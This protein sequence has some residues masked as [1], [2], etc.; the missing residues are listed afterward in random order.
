MK[1]LLDYIINNQLVIDKGSYLTIVIGQITVYA[2]LLTFYQFIVLFQGTKDRYVQRYLGTKLKDYFVKK[3]LTIYNQ[4]VS[5]PWFGLLFIL[6]ILYKPI[7]SIYGKV[8]PDNVITVFNFIWYVYIVF[9][10]VVFVA[11]FFQ[12]MKCILSIELATDKRCN[13][14]IIRCINNEFRK[15]TFDDRLKKSSIKML[16]EAM[17][18]ISNS[19]AEDDDSELQT[20]YNKLIIDIFDDY[21]KGKEK[22][23]SLLL[24]KNK[25]GKNHTE[26]IDNMN[27]ERLLLSEFISGKYTQMN[28]LLEKYIQD[29]HLRLLNLNLKRA[30]WNGYEKISIDI[31]DSDEDSLDCREWRILTEDIFEKSVLKN[32]KIM[33]ET[34]YSGSRSDHRLFKKYCEK[35]LL[36]IMRKSVWEVFEDKIQQKDFVYVF[37]HVLLDTEFNSFYAKEVCDNLISYNEI[38]VAE[39][40]K[41]LNKENC[42]YIFAYLV[43]YYSIYKF[44]FEWKNINI[45]MLKELVRNGKS[46]KSEFERINSIISKSCINHRYSENMYIALVENLYKEITGRWLE[47]IYHQ[48]S[49]DAFYITIIKL[50]VFEQNYYSFYQEG[51]I[52]AKISFINELAK[53]KEVLIYD[54]VKEMLWQMQYNDFCKLDYWPEK[55]HI[56]LRSLLLMNMSITDEQLDDMVQ[57]FHH[58]S[59]GQY[60]LVKHVGEKSIGEIKKDLIRKAYVASNMPI[61]EYVEF[62][63]S[64]CCICGVDCSYVKKEKMKSDLME[65][66]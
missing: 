23:L 50:C 6:E 49:I 8:I 64:E 55:L 41:L 29:L 40:I 61:Q 21:E 59:V 16:M 35:N 44:R 46:L 36:Y 53:H 20:E 17:K 26:W 56:T 39:L 25:K 19:I 5:K 9:F 62:L 1:I 7:I 18:A 52:E 28:Y 31:F 65:L 4:I 12:C 57:Y 48:K 10:F 27:D 58:I 34:L 14:D 33:I 54:N 47:E 51:G 38:N 2:I 43:I 15:R 13:T 22:E 3:R 42:T 30:L 32:K 60:L 63:Y 37:E 11:L 24:A 66:I 45:I